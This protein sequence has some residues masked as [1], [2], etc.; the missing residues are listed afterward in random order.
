MS[1]THVIQMP[2]FK[3]VYKKLHPKKKWIIDNIIQKI[4]D[5]PTVGNIK[6]GELSDI[7][8]YKFKKIKHP[9]FFV[10]NCP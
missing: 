4:I 7:F 3:R 6:K 10:K 1:E 2:L 8:V 5:N 9:L